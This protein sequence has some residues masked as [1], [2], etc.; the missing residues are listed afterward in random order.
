[1]W[2]GEC[3]EESVGRGVWGGECEEGSVG[4][5]VWEGE[6]GEGSGILFCMGRKELSL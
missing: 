5:G 3:G 2:G 4:R 6:C 1:M